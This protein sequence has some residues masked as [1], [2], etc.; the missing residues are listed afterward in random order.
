ML[1]FNVV[2]IIVVFVNKVILIY[3]KEECQQKKSPNVK[4][5]SQKPKQ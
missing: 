3:P 5:N 1:V 4:K 2:V